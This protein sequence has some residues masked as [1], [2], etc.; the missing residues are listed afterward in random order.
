MMDLEFKSKIQ[1]LILNSKL[2]KD[3]V[4]NTKYVKKILDT[5]KFSER[6]ILKV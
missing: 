3:N 6:T 1:S 2:L 4:L 5:Q